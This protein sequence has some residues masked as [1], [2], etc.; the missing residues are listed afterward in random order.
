MP[1]LLTLTKIDS[2]GIVHATTS[3]DIAGADLSA[4]TANPFHALLGPD[5]AVKRVILAMNRTSYV[6]SAAVG[7]LIMCQREFK[8]SGGALVLFGV[9]ESVRQ[10][11][12]LLKIQ[13][14]IPIAPDET[15]ARAALGALQ[16]GGA[17]L[18]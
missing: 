1:E 13:K 18:G 14:L 10:V 12:A 8:K 7:W 5:W 9:P 16:M 15:A 3:G 11:L 6:D 17:A 2:R 4:G